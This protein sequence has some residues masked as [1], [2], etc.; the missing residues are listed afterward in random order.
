MKHKINKT[1]FKYKTKHGGMPPGI[2]PGMP[3]AMLDASQPIAVTLPK[4]SI[5]QKIINFISSIKGTLLSFAAIIAF[6]IL[7]LACY[8]VNKLFTSLFAGINL[9][10]TAINFIV[11]IFVKMLKIIFIRLPYKKINPMPKTLYDLVLKSIPPL[12]PIF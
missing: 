10:I 2:P 1:K 8:I 7:L 11:G 12:P 5:L 3:P 4:L 6:F 9:I